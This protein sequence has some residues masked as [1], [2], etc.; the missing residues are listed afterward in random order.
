MGLYISIRGPSLAVGC[1]ERLPE[2][3]NLSQNLEDDQ[4]LPEGSSGGK[5]RETARYSEEIDEE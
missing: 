3:M 4:E 1:W 2:D 5:E